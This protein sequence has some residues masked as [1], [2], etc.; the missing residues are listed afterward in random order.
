MKKNVGNVS[1]FEL[2][3]AEVTSANQRP[4]VIQRQSDREVAYL[5]LNGIVP[6]FTQKYGLKVR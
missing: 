1:E 3:R 4:I 2:L 5:R 6:P